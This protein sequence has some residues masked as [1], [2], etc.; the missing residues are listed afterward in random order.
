[1][2]IYYDG[3]LRKN[4]ICI[5]D[6]ESNLTKILKRQYDNEDYE[7]DALE[8]ALDYVK[9]MQ[10]EEKEIELIGDNNQVTRWIS[11]PDLL[12]SP[13]ILKQKCKHKMDNLRYNGYKIKSIWVKRNENLAGRV[14]EYWTGRSS[15]PAIFV[16]KWYE[17]SRCVFKSLKEKEK[18]QHFYNQ[19]ITQG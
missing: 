9:E 6:A 15:K 13:T 11:D 7:W 4:L 3:G 16:A 18:E 1:M 8:L 19:H 14:L 5:V 10:P 2:I 12:K 17:C